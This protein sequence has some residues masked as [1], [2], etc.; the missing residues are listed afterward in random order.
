MLDTLTWEQ[1]SEWI[2]YYE[3]EP[4]G[5]GRADERNEVFSR[6]LVAR[7]F[8]QSEGETLPNAMYPYVEKPMTRE[9]EAEMRKRTEEALVW[10][11]ERYVWRE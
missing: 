8:G 2:A 10:N 1:F 7:I 3:L 9:E 5:E 4:W 11:G 6:R